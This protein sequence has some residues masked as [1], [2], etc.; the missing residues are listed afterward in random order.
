MS[1]AEGRT[2]FE[3][4]VLQTR[5]RGARPERL[6]AVPY[7]DVVQPIAAQTI[8]VLPTTINLNIYQG[9]DFFLDVTVMDANNNPVVCTNS[10]PLSQIRLSPNDLTILANLAITVDATTTNLL[11]LHLLAADSNLLPLVTAWDLQLS[12]PNVLT[13]AAGVVNCTPQVTE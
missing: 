2:G 6:S 7:V 10:Q 1:E 5:T 12:S 4:R 3:R 8:T 11:H 9:D 13:I